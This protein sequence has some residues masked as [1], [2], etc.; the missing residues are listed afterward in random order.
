MDDILC[1]ASDP[2]T[3]IAALTDI[4]K[5]FSKL[6]GYGVNWNKLEAFAITAF[7]PKTYFMM[8]FICWRKYHG[9]QLDGQP[10]LHANGESEH[11]E[12]N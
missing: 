11:T 9:M 2:V 4:I 12:N 7:C 3:S 1:F 8:L 5:Y 10:Y 6:S